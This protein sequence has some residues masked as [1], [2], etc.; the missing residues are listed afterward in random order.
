MLLQ[1]DSPSE[2]ASQLDPNLNFDAQIE[3]NW[4]QNSTHHCNINSDDIVLS[5]FEVLDKT[6]NLHESYMHESCSQVEEELTEPF[7]SD[8]QVEQLKNYKNF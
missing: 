2:N 7:W 3:S 5:R 8:S 6:I 4:S 1:N